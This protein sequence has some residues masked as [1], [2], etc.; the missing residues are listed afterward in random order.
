MMR[1]IIIVLLVYSCGLSGVSCTGKNCFNFVA[2]SLRRNVEN[3]LKDCECDQDEI[4]KFVNE[5]SKRICFVKDSL[6]N[7]DSFDRDSFVDKKDICTFVVDLAID[8]ISIVGKKKLNC[9]KDFYSCLPRVTLGLE[10]I[11]EKI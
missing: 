8:Y 10:S 3:G 9:K 4:G 6:K 7:L 5:V 2:S 1:F 11:C